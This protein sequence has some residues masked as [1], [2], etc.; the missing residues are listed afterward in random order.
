MYLDSFKTNA[1]SVSKFG[2]SSPLSVFENSVFTR[3]ISTISGTFSAQS[4]KTLVSTVVINSFGD[5]KNQHNS[6]AIGNSQ[7]FS[8]ESN[9]CYSYTHLLMLAGGKRH[10]VGLHYRMFDRADPRHRLIDTK[11]KF[12]QEIQ[13]ASS[14]RYGNFYACVA[15]AFE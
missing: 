8:R 15:S 13:C 11:S 9:N 3:P 14:W 7:D 2:A 10:T 1:K 5:E 6:L 4:S 12:L